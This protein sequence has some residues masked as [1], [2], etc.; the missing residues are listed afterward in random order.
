MVFC[1]LLGSFPYCSAASPAASQLGR[2]LGAFPVL[3][4]GAAER[5][6]ACAKNALLAAG[7]R[8]WGWQGR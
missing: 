1:L 4:I 2:G 6:K 7:V 8:G 5:G 3:A